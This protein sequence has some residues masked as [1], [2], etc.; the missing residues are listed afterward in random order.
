MEGRQPAVLGVSISAFVLASLFVALRFISRILI[1]RKVVL[2]D[3]LM[4]IA[5]VYSPVWWFYE[6]STSNTP[7][8]NRLWVLIFIVLCD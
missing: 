4:L 1:V 6:A 3:Y 5:W 8:G 7:P 2:H